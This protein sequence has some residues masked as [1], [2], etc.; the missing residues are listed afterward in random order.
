M[1]QRIINRSL[2]L[3]TDQRPSPPTLD[4]VHKVVYICSSH[5]LTDDELSGSNLTEELCSTLQRLFFYLHWDD[6]VAESEPPD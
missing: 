2:R 6:T 3:T 1:A 5:L 4:V